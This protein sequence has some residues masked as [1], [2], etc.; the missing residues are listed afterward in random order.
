M[1]TEAIQGAQEVSFTEIQVEDDF[2]SPWIK[3]IQEATIPHLIDLAEEQ[4]EIGN[5]R[6]IAGRQN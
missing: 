1:T 6:I 4:G 3:T 5:L 2:W